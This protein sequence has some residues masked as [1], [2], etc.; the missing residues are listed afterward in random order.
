M[1]ERNMKLADLTA[2][3]RI[4][5]GVSLWGGSYTWPD[6]YIELDID[7][8]AG[9]RRDDDSEVRD[10]L[11]DRYIARKS[12]SERRWLMISIPTLLLATL[13]YLVMH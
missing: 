12:A 4:K 10:L 7:S 5:R 13:A 11:L 1:A 6:G 9:V 3:Q 8:A 2:W